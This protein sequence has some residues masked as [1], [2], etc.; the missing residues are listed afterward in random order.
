M[1]RGHVDFEMREWNDMHIVERLT[2]GLQRLTLDPERLPPG[3]LAQPLD[4]E[5]LLPGVLTQRLDPE[6]LLP[7]LLAQRLDPVAF[8]HG[9]APLAHGL[10]RQR[11]GA[12]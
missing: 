2:H 7:D 9:R 10:A 3:V 1:S 6:R 12:L 4:P 5:R 11:R 8:A